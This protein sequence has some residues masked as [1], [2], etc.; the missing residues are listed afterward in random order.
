[1]TYPTVPRF[2]KDEPALDILAMLMG[3]GKSSIFYKNFVKNEKAIF[4]KC[5]Y[6]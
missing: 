6:S 3:N 1:M 4:L 5:S 2:H